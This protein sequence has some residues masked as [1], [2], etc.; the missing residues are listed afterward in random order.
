[1]GFVR[2]RPVPVTIY[3]AGL[4]I[5]TDQLGSFTSNT[6]Q[7]LACVALG[8]AGYRSG[9]RSVAL[10]VGVT[11]VATAVNM[12][13]PGIA[14]T[15]N[16]WVYSVFLPI[17]PALLGAYLRGS[18]GRLEERDVTPDALLAA[19]GV[20][21][22]V[23][24]TWT[25]WHTGTQPVWVVGL[26]AVVGGLS[27]G[28][29][30]RL[31]GVVFLAQGVLLVSADTYLNEAV[32]TCVI[33]TL[34]SIGVFAMRVSSWAWTIVAYLTGC[35]L[36]AVAVVGPDTVVTP[37]RTGILMTLVATPIAIG[38]Y[39]GM[40][41]AAA[42]A[43]RRRAEEAARAAVTQVRA[44]QLAE[45]ERIARE[46]HDIVAHHVGAMVLRAG[47]ARY[48]APDGPVA[49]ALAD[50]RETGHQVLQDLREL[51]DLLRDPERRPEL[52]ADP[53]DVVRESAERMAAAG[54]LVDLDLDPA[55]DQ[56]PLIARASAARIVQEGL[57][58]VLKHAGP[59]TRVRVTVAPAEDGL[60]VEI[61]NGRP[62]TA[63]ERL[64][65]S[66]RGLAG[67]RERVRTLGGSLTAGPDG[68]GGWLLA[69]S[70]PSRSA[71]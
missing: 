25:S 31:P 50:I 8:V 43:E 42:A 24:S 15:T 45:R 55:T 59:G 28:I 49:D 14:F 6:A 71:A 35:L 36:T 65:S 61:R 17:F 11:V 4:L 44:D 38:R 60:S 16:S 56:A 46:V 69:A 67:M 19:G 32:N 52:L 29:A 58:N 39:L 27:L 66:G 54:L 40:R 30:R 7:I 33:L 53:S 18:A 22:T 64:P 62:P 51:L 41:Q 23:L 5:V 34:V 37:F 70:L 10:A 57:T 48:A 9:W 3:L 63:V 21:I 13:D 1:M 68:E 47:A 12:A 26:L 20:A 2:R